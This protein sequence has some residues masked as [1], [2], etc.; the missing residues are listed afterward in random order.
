MRKGTLKKIVEKFGIDL[1]YLFGSKTDEGRRYLEGEEIASD[2]YS[3]LD[4]AVAFERLPIE[5]VQVYGRLYREMSDLFDP[6]RIDLILLHE[7][8]SLFQYEIIKGERIYERDITFADDFEERIMRRAEDLSYKKR[9]F[10]GEV[11]EA[12]EHG[13]FEFEYIPN[14]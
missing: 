1:V 11:L 8:N 6:F 4:I 14:P 5:T 13:Y 2:P 12:M 3:D 9:I 7:M 10:D